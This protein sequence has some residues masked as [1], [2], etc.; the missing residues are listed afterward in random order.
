MTPHIS[1]KTRFK[2]LQMGGYLDQYFTDEE[3]FILR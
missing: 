3:L 1:E 2:D